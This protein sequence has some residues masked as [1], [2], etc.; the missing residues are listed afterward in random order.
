MADV[1]GRGPSVQLGDPDA[2]VAGLALFT[3]G[4]RRRSHRGR[5]HADRQP[6]DAAQYTTKCPGGPGVPAASAGAQ[7]QI[8][9]ET[10]IRPGPHSCP[11]AHR[12]G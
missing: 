9:H 1:T 7:S 3:D 4:Q 10:V 6:G 12:S 11:S 5:Y 8:D 2:Y